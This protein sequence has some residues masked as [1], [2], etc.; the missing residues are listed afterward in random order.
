LAPRFRQS[1][2]TTNNDPNSKDHGALRERDGAGI[3]RRMSRWRPPPPKS[4]AIISAQGYAALEKELREK[5]ELRTE[6]TAALGAAAAEGDRS[7][8]AEYIYRKKQ[9]AEIDRRIRYLQRRMPTLKVVR[10]AGDTSRVFFGADVTL[11]KEDGGE[12][13]YRIVGPDETNAKNGWISIDSPLARALL[14]KE[15]EDEVQI[16]LAGNTID[17]C[18]IDI[19]YNM[20][21]SKTAATKRTETLHDEDT[22]DDIAELDDATDHIDLTSSSNWVSAVGTQDEDLIL[23]LTSKSDSSTYDS[24]YRYPNAASHAEPLKSARYPGKYVDEQIRPEYDFEKVDLEDPE[25]ESFV[26][27]VIRNNIG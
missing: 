15:I 3:L 26:T 6:V 25:A 5:W 19:A 14:K 21:V 11:E 17:Y 27:E 12:V 4:T 13:M 20:P 22:D 23:I 2:T 10:E 1:P 7:E 16:T 9:L 24:C 8:N 18:V